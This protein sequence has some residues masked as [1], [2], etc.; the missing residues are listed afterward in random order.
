MGQVGQKERQQTTKSA[1]SAHCSANYLH[2][3]G[4]LLA[5]AADE[6]VDGDLDTLPTLIAIHGIVTTADGGNSTEVNRLGLLEELLH[7]AGSRAGG[8]VTTITEEVDVDLRDLGFLGG[9]QKCKEVVDVTVD[10]TVGDL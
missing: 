4:G 10:S 3:V 7:V 5:L 1:K 9:I 2:G 8:G 6:T